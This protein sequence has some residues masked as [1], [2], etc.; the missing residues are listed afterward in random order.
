MVTLLFPVYNNEIIKI[1]LLFC[2][3]QSGNNFYGHKKISGSIYITRIFLVSSYR[4][5]ITEY[6]NSH[7]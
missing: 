5:V 3:Q 7:I 2:I 4:Q 1:A 6:Q